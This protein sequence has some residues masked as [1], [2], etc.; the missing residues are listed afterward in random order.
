[1]EY[2]MLVRERDGDSAPSQAIERAE[3]RW[4]VDTLPFT[5]AVSPWRVEGR[6]R[7]DDRGVCRFPVPPVQGPFSLFVK[8]DGRWRFVD[9]WDVGGESPCKVEAVSIRKPV[10]VTRL[11][12]SCLAV[13]VLDEELGT[14]LQGAR[15]SRVIQHD[16]APPGVWEPAVT[17]PDGRVTFDGLGAREWH[18]QVDI[19]LAGYVPVRSPGHFSPMGARVYYADRL[20]RAREVQGRVVDVEGVP[21]AQALVTVYQLDERGRAFGEWWYSSDG[22]GRFTAL[23]AAD[24][25]ALVEVEKAGYHESEAR[26]ASVGRECAVTMRR[27]R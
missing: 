15:V 16:A 4:Y 8:L 12:T 21:V 11:G 23:V 25:E 9:A 20:L 5:S 17:G 18:G 10:E 13:I 24:G 19:T 27:V 2:S 1:M 6:A 3:V 22:Q 7:T 14:P 26:V